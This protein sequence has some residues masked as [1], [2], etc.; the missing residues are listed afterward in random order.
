MSS[1][2]FELTNDTGQ[3]LIDEFSRQVEIVKTVDGLVPGALTPWSEM[4]AGI[5][6]SEVVGTAWRDPGMFNLGMCPGIVLPGEGYH[7]YP[8]VKDY[9]IFARCN[10]PLGNGG[11][12]AFTPLVGQCFTRWQ[13]DSNNQ[14]GVASNQIRCTY[15]GIDHNIPGDPIYGVDHSLHSYLNYVRKSFG[16]EPDYHHG[17]QNQWVTPTSSTSRHP[18]PQTQNFT[19]NW[20]A[21]G[22]D[23]GCYQLEVVSHDATDIVG[24]TLQRT[25]PLSLR[26]SPIFQA[27]T[28]SSN[29]NTIQLTGVTGIQPGDKVTVR[30]QQWMTNNNVN[31]VVPYAS[32][33]T[34]ASVNSA[35]N[36]VT[37]NTGHHIGS[38]DAG[39]W[40]SF[41]DEN[42]TVTDV[43]P[44]GTDYM[45]T[46]SRDVVTRVTG[47]S[48]P[49]MNVLF[50]AR[51]PN[52]S[53]KPSNVNYPTLGRTEYG[54]HPRAASSSTG[55]T[56]TLRADGTGA[57]F[58]APVGGKL[59]VYSST[60]V[61]RSG[62]QGT[63]TVTSVNASNNTITFDANVSVT[64]GDF[65]IVMDDQGYTVDIKLGKL[66][67]TAEENGTHGLQVFD[68]NGDLAWSSNRQNFVIENIS[69]SSNLNADI[70]NISLYYG[71]PNFSAGFLDYEVID[72]ANW[73]DYWVQVQ[74]FDITSLFVEGAYGGNSNGSYAYGVGYFWNFPSS[75]GQLSYDNP[76]EYDT[77]HTYTAYS[78]TN[79]S[80]SDELGIGMGPQVMQYYKRTITRVSGGGTIAVSDAQLLNSQKTLIVGKFI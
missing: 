57:T 4:S 20:S 71:T 6:N 39:M 64:A 69:Y 21:G 29:A 34:V 74:A 73:E 2:G 24:C 54:D 75:S 59:Y 5:Y 38:V 7:P 9:L 63:R 31:N 27:A 67:N 46:F 17:L 1:Y 52:L 3:Q 36:T 50:L 19:W 58:N 56:V 44:S 10:D 16:N 80:A 45:L 72:K 47:T 70:Y 12:V 49:I 26:I 76:F 40:F 22:S 60:G 18:Y 28:A 53:W 55:S 77:Q 11:T 48:Y 35:N 15:E 37:F 65:I 66:T 41:E 23:V 25:T 42:A 13:I 30:S 51:H 78:P 61:P 79:K 43:S 68:A 32:Q 33:V 62:L 8:T 14:S